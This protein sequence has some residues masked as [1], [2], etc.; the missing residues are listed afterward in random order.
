MIRRIIYYEYNAI[1]YLF[2]RRFMLGIADVHKGEICNAFFKM[3]NPS[4]IRKQGTSPE[5]ILIH[6]QTGQAITFSIE[7]LKKMLL[8]IFVEP[9]GYKNENKFVY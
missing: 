8:N 1:V 2:N 9:L 4:A 3:K 7:N 6:K 5:I